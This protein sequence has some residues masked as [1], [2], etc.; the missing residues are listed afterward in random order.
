MTPATAVAVA[1]EACVLSASAVASS[2]STA[3]TAAA[4]AEVP[5]AGSTD[6]TGSGGGGAAER[7]SRFRRI[8][9]YC[10]S[11]KGKKA[12]YQDAAIDLGN[13]LVR[14]RIRCMIHSTLS[15]EP[16]SKHWSVPFRSVPWEFIAMCTFG[17]AR[18]IC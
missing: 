1:S 15:R 6:E 7:R 17:D 18:S 2:S 13:Q 3:G 8:C 16:A 12:S 4:R 9:V 10:G 14:T 11:A 5:A